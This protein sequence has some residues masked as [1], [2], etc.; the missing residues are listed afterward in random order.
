M[1]DLE[2]NHMN[3]EN[4]C[5]FGM[6]NYIALGVFYGTSYL[7]SNY[8]YI[9]YA[10]LISQDLVL[11][12]VLHWVAPLNGAQWLLSGAEGSTS[13]LNCQLCYM[14]EWIWPGWCTQPLPTPITLLA[15]ACWH[16][17]VQFQKEMWEAL[18]SS[19]FHCNF[20]MSSVRHW[21]SCCCT[22]H[23]AHIFSSGKVHWLNTLD[24]HRAYLPLFM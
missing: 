10:T 22:C 17:N 23:I 8:K 7:I 2:I 11:S 6:A 3:K 15:C 18:N 1:Q 14:Y 21:C 19:G 5:S 13:Q 12:P 4:Y 16:W 9:S 24:Y 20:C